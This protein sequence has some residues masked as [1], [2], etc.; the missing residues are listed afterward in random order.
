[1]RYIE[2]FNYIIL[3]QHTEA[4]SLYLSFQLPSCALS[5][6]DS[7]LHD[8]SRY[9]SASYDNMTYDNPIDTSSKL[10]CESGEYNM[11]SQGALN[12]SPYCL[13]A[14]QE[15]HN[16]TTSDSIYNITTPP[17]EQDKRI[18]CDISHNNRFMI[19]N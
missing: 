7:H 17:Y 14:S 2:T 11:F 13:T 3:C 8:I 10:Y 5:R 9:D 18:F 6:N 19:C 16:S 1:M 12:D 4:Y 15:L